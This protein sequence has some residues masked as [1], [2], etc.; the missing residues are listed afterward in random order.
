MR[1]KFD[2]IYPCRDD[3]VII[4]KLSRI[5]DLALS[6]IYDLK[7]ALRAL[8]R[9]LFHQDF[10]RLAVGDSNEDTVLRILH[11]YS[12]KVVVDGFVFGCLD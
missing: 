6:E 5:I 7:S 4:K 8:T 2:C 1:T 11:F 9:C 3:M 12:L 10:L